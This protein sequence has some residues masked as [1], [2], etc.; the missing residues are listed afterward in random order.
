[1]L[2]D[3]ELRLLI[4]LHRFRDGYAGR[5]ERMGAPAA[6]QLLVVGGVVAALTER[7]HFKV[8]RDDATNVRAG[9]GV[10]SPRLWLVFYEY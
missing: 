8:H 1:M 3:T 4:F 7:H 6:R 5:V 9:G 2:Q 10:V